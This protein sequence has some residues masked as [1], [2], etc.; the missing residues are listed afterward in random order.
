MLILSMNRLLKAILPAE[1]FLHAS[2]VYLQFLLEVGVINAIS[3]VFSL[4]LS[5]LTGR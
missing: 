4:W 1:Q 2:L 3:L 5:V